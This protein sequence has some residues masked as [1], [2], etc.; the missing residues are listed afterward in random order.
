MSEW[1]SD[2]PPYFAVDV[3]A[4]DISPW[5]A[6]NTGIRGFTTIASSLPGPHVAVVALIHGNELAG[7]V[8]LDAMLRE[9]VQIARGRLTL[10]RRSRP[11]RASSTRISTGCGTRRCW[12][13]PAARWSSTAPG[14]YGR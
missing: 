11:P 7:A 1:G 14:I 10:G 4:P 8:V 2:A 9:G 3:A 5:L 6:G 13:G 12:M